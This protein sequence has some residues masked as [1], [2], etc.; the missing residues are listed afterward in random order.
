M[1]H[2]HDPGSSTQNQGNTLGNRACV[3]QSSLFRQYESGNSVKGLLGTGRLQW[4]TNQKEGAYS[5]QP[6][7]SLFDHR[8]GENS[9]V[10]DGGRF[11]A[12]RR[13]FETNSSALG[14][15]YIPQQQRQLPAAHDFQSRTGKQATNPMLEEIEHRKVQREA[16]RRAAIEAVIPAL[17]Y[18]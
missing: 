1:A 3:R 18:V 5:G 9:R 11:E 6:V 10:H 13:S 14:A 2:Y 8:T 15:H 4:D 12:P 7:G 17:M 16:A